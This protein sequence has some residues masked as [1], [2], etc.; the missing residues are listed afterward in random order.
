MSFAAPKAVSGGTSPVGAKGSDRGAQPVLRAQGVT[1]YYGH[2][3]GIV[4][5]SLECWPGEVHALV[6][7]NG[8][9]KSTFM[10]SVA[11]VLRPR[12]GAI[13]IDGERYRPGSVRRAHRSGI[14]TVFQELSLVPH[15]TAVENLVLY[16]R[17]PSSIYRSGR[18]RSRARA[19]LEEWCL[20]DVP[21]DVP[22]SELALAVR[23][24]LE[25]V[26][27]FATDPHVLILD[28]ATSALGAPRVDWLMDAIRRLVASGTAVIYSSHR[29]NEIRDIADRGTVLRDGS[30]VGSFDRASFDSGT[31]ISLMVGRPAEAAYPER[32]AA[33]APEAESMLV[34][35]GLTG[36]NLHGID[37]DVRAGEILGI[38]G[39]QGHGQ[40]ELLAALMGGLPVHA[41]TWRVRDRTVR[42]MTTQLARSLGFGFVPEDRKTQGLAYDMNVGEN[43]L[44]PR[45][46]AVGLGG[47]LALRRWHAWLSE[48][49]Q[50]LEIVPPK[51]TLSVAELSGGN[52]QKVVVGRWLSPELRVLLLVDPTRGIDIA[53]KQRL[54]RL[55]CGLSAAGVAIL[56]YS[57]DVDELVHLCHRVAVL[58]RGEIV[59][60]LQG[61]SLTASAV[62][63][64]SLGQGNGGPR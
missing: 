8:A 51:V 23:Q 34:V 40:T 50:S 62:V 7:G 58:Y 14:A 55:F 46:R 39:L 53:A 54:Y 29:L 47:R 6:G 28:E 64:A 44:A 2:V 57:T 18:A 30:V 24:Q 61:D 12:D 3:R 35:E 11:G 60:T 38:G 56:W 26:R 19:T 9:G 59:E 22:V 1:H 36:R 41:R 13:E 31:I 5:V 52:Q 17:A 49:V 32:P 4:D 10:K 43:L 27:A 37:L 42:H 15:W 25:I 48:T 20:G 16:D 21:L 33:V 45:V 63:G